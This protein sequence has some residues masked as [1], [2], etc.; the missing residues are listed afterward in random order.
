MLLTET[1]QLIHTTP[2]KPPIQNKNQHTIIMT[3]NQRIPSKR[4][5]RFR[6]RNIHF[7]I[8]HIDIAKH[9]RKLAV[10]DSPVVRVA[11][12]VCKGGDGFAEGGSGPEDDVVGRDAGFVF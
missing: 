10:E 12:C 6:T 8:I 3:K 4:I 11:V 9:F 1:H 7:P 2:P 5:Q